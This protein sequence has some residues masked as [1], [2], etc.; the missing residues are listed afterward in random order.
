VDCFTNLHGFER[1][2]SIQHNPAQSRT[3]DD[4][5]SEKSIVE[6]LDPIFATPAPGGGN[7]PPTS[8]RENS[9]RLHAPVDKAEMDEAVTE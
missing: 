4:D 8:G 2:Q 6:H 3:S 9:S 1:S 7:I 5:R